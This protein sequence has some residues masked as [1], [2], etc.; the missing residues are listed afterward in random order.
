MLSWILLI[1]V[2]FVFAI[3]GI[4]VSAGLF[5]RGEALPPL[6]EPA[7]VIESNRRAVDEGRID[8]IVLEVVPRGYRQDQVDALIAQLTRTES[9]GTESVGTESVG[10]ES[11]RTELFE[12][13][14]AEPTAA[15]VPSVDAADAQPAAVEKSVE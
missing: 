10:T 2:V 6:D 12:T 1:A 15:K 9:V 14:S 3:L 5:G 13:E 11:D 4:W 8:D 7:K